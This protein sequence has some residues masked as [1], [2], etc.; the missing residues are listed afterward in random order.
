MGAPRRCSSYAAHAIDQRGSRVAVDERQRRARRRPSCAR[1]RS[2]RASRC[3]SRR[4]SRTAQ[5]APA[6]QQLERRRL[7][8]QRH[9]ASRRERGETMRDRP[10]ALRRPVRRA[11]A[12]AATT[13]WLVLRDGQV[14]TAHAPAARWMMWRGA[15]R[16]NAAGED[17]RARPRSTHRSELDGW[18]RGAELAHASGFDRRRFV[19]QLL[20][21]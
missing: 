3:R 12:E 2:R 11:M 5:A 21:A 15:E 19:R 7:V 1:A 17:V 10:R 18:Q 4:P 20:G 9:Q 6:V 16:R 8:E 14:R 13:V